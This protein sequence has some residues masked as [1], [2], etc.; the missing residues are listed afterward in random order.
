M[1]LS[2]SDFCQELIWWVLEYIGVDFLATVLP[3]MCPGE[4]DAGIMIV[5][6][7]KFLLV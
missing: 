3:S 4:D 5:F 7:K 1:Y 6:G 2:P